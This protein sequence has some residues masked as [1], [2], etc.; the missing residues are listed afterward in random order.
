MYI[1]TLTR[2][3]EA[4]RLSRYVMTLHAAE[5][6]EDDAF[7]VYDVERCILNGAITERQK[8]MASGEWK[9]LIQ[10][11]TFLDKGISVAAKF[12]VTGKLVIITIYAT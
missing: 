10:G 8:D 3:R 5:E 6:M 7:T 12:S 4:V 1:R 9:Y 11:T 2:M